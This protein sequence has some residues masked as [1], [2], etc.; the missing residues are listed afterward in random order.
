MARPTKCTKELI[1]KAREYLE[2]YEDNGSKIP[3]IDGLALYIEIHRDTIY[4]WVSQGDKGELRDQF[5]DIV[6]RLLATQAEILIDKGL[7]KTFDGRIVKLMLSKHGYREA[8]DTD[9]TSGGEV[10]KGFEYVVPKND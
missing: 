7:D 5:S 9:I 1:E 2:T 6:G 10:L 3:S 4:D 8:I